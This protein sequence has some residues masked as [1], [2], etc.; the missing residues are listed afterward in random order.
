LKQEHERQRLIHV[1]YFED[2]MRAL[3][4]KQAQ[5][6]LHL[7]YETGTGLQHLAVSAPT[8]PPRLNAQ[9]SEDNIPSRQI[10]PF[11][12]GESLTKA[13]K[14]KSV[15][16]APTVNLSPDLANNPAGIN[17]TR[18]AGAKSMPAS[19]R[20]SASE[21]DEDLAGHIQGLSLAGGHSTTA[22]P[23]PGPVAT[24]ALYR[25][26]GRYSD[27]QY[28]SVYNAGM[29]LDEQLDKEMH[30]ESFFLTAQPCLFIIIQ[31]L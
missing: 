13:D 8:T 29:M 22:S 4:E 30:S 12:D 25:G 20:T 10:R 17:Y 2:Q 15:T 5:E 27:E 26:N 1:K 19:R 28:A 14:R 3:R 18:A 24:A 6:L 31:M 16:Y 9:L 7:P 21:H 23:G 11:L